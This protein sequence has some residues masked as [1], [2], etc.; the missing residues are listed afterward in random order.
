MRNK[1]NA[2]IGEVNIHLNYEN[3]WYDMGIIIEAKYRGKGYAV[4]ALKQAFEVLDARA[5]HNNFESVRDAAIK[6]HLSAGFMKHKEEDGI[7]ELTI[8]KEQYDLIK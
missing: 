1:D 4:E 6:T 8:T 2:F 7:V 3:N 5:V